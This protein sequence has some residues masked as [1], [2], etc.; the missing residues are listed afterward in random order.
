MRL[1]VLSGVLLWVGLALLLSE[2]RWFS[3]PSLAERL[4]PYSPGGMG[5]R[6]RAGVL[7][8]ESFRD[9]VGPLARSLG[10]RLARLVGVNEELAV[11]LERVHSS[12]D[13]TAFRTRQLGWA[14]VS[15]G[16]AALISLAARPT[17]VIA[18]LFLVGAPTLSFL[19]LEQRL[20]SASEAWKQ[21]LALELPVVTEQLAMLLAA[22]FSLG[23][24]LNRVGV[25]GRGNCAR[26]LARV[27]RKSVV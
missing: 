12:V 23:A 26:D 17:P 2:A 25:R 21:R 18:L 15:L 8:G 24:A 27:D 3:R 10:E 4:V 22:G 19:T 7:S 5:R 20:S 16:G 14:V 6:P 9:I 11:R 1:V 13:V